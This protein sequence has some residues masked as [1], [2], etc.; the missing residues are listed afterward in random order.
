MYFIS[1]QTNPRHR[2][3]SCTFLLFAEDL[4]PLR[5]IQDLLTRLS[6]LPGHFIECLLPLQLQLGLVVSQ[7]IDYS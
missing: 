4:P 3:N 5:L 7:L 1:L 6:M 2:L